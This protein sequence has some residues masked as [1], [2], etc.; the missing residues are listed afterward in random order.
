MPIEE[1]VVRRKRGSG[2]GVV[3]PIP[4]TIP[5]G[6]AGP[7]AGFEP[8][9][10]GPRAF[11]PPPIPEPIPEIVVK[12]KRQ[13][14]V[15]GV[16]SRA[17]ALGSYW[18]AGIG[19]IFTLDQYRRALET[20]QDEKSKKEAE[21]RRLR[22]LAREKPLPEIIVREKRPPARGFAPPGPLVLPPMP[23]IF[24]GRDDPGPDPFIMEPIIPPQAPVP[25]APPP[26]IAPPA[27]PLPPIRT[28][29]RTPTR[30]PTRTPFRI[31]PG[32]P[33]RP[34]IRP[35]IFPEIAPA[36]APAPPLPAPAPRVAPAPAIAPFV[37]PGPATAPGLGTLLS[38]PTL[39]QI[40][41][42]R[43]RL[44]EPIPLPQAQAQAQRLCR[45]CPKCKKDE[46]KPRNECW[47]VL[48]KESRFPR[49]DTKYNWERIDCDTGR[50]LK[51]PAL[52]R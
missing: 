42:R 11:L 38:N 21:E 6:G 43:A 37:S 13:A 12:A 35:D 16:A 39:T 26:V 47:R 31:R 10:S 9:D 32:T 52:F 28:P 30:T 27:P 33:T 36:P 5:F 50:P 40:R 1:I 20:E 24:P 51:G 41:T 3:G 23:I 8:P 17:L 14:I 45:P 49:D 19:V 46:D 44:R 7:G 29:I 2:P 22:R 4:G 25:V 18:L 34:D 48:V 15:R